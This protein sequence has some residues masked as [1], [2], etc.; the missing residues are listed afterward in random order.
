MTR[1]SRWDLVFLAVL[2]IGAIAILP[3][4]FGFQIP[5]LT[6][7]VVYAIAAGGKLGF[8]ILSAVFAAVSFVRF[9]RDN[10]ARTPWLLLALGLGGYSLG[11]GTIVFYQVVLRVP[12]PFPSVADVF[13]LAAMVGLTAALVAFLVAFQRAGFLLAGPRTVL[14]QGL[15]TAA[16]LAVLA[17]WLLRPIVLAG[18]SWVELFLNLAYPISDLVLTVPALLLLLMARRFAGGRVARVWFALLLGLL[19]MAGGDVGFAYFSSMGL[20][21]LK[22]VVDFLYFGSYLALAR[23]T[24]YQVELLGAR[25][26]VA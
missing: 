24:L 7:G 23:A 19:L 2:V 18:G 20:G 6:E 1:S 4:G 10:P 9:D 15:S 16:V 21:N 14:L 17:I 5:L 12:M 25:E 22:P 13:F 11:Q 26:T 8:L 3:W